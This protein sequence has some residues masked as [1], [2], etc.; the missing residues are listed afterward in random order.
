[1]LLYKYD[2][3]TKEYLNE[4]MEA[5]VDPITSQKEGRPIVIV[6]PNFT[7]AEPLSVGENE[8]A[9]FNEEEQIWRKEEDYRGLKGFN[10]KTKKE[11]E[12]TELGPLP[13]NF[14]LELNETLQDTRMK[15]IQEIKKAYE[16]EVRNI[17]VSQ[18]VKGDLLAVNEEETEKILREIMEKVATV[19]ERRVALIDTVLGTRSKDKIRGLEISLNIDELHE[20]V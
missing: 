3:N 4:T 17:V 1:M 2:E 13:K 14:V 6:P 19:L 16:D 12:I 20:G 18:I 10:S 8:V 11:V 9:I 7:L 5:L 15:K